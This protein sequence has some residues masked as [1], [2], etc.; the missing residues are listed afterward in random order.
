[1]SRLALLIARRYL[2]SK[3]TTN[4]INVL[5]GIS[6]FGMFG[7]T[8]AL[9]VVLSVFNGF[10]SL[11]TS[12]YN[13]FNPD[14]KISPREGKVFVPTEAQW[15]A[16]RQIRG[17]G[18][19][20]KVLEENAFFK[21]YENGDFGRLKGVDSAFTQVSNVDTAIIEGEY[22]LNGY[23][24]EYSQ[25]D[26]RAAYG[27]T[28]ALSPDQAPQPDRLLNYA[29]MGYVLQAKL[30]ISLSDNFSALR[31]F[32]PLRIG[33]ASSTALE[34]AYKQE[35]VYAAGIFSIQQDLDSKYVIVP[36][37]FVR[38]LLD[39][40][41]GEVSAIEI[42]VPNDA[43]IATVQ[44]ELQRVW[45]DGFKVRN[46]YQQDETLYKVMRTEKLAVYI[47]LI[48][49]LILVAFN[50]VGSLSIL[51]IEK[52]RDIGILKAMG[53]TRSFIERVFLFESMLLA[54]IGSASGATLA[55]AICWAQQQFKIIKLQG[56]SFLV[57]AYPVQMQWLDF[58][59]VGL[60]VFVIAFIAAYLPAKRAAEQSQLLLQE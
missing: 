9:I 25:A 47:I 7:G 33:D 52:K 5:S 60:A 35:T 15:A 30:G 16:M 57:D 46:R 1:M 26:H 11:V 18:A 10:E 19:T 37:D 59:W 40:T 3:K 51:V 49:M 34:N 41:Q 53:A 22:R 24:S 8:M 32:M 21:Y 58:V 48:F 43:D 36:I 45:G 31:V 20:A 44:R 6:M 55:V 17:I 50:M 38:Q 12:L 23:L 29:V 28:A 4:A 56:N 14:L 2:V 39:Y 13:T 54:F 42:D 27:D